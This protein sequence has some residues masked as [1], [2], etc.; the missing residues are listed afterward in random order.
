MKEN[1]KLVWRKIDEL[2]PYE[3][4]AKLHPQEQIDRLVGSFDE[5]GRIVPA[6]IDKDGNLI[7]GHGRILAARQRGDVDFPCIEIDGL[8]EVQ[9]RA[10]VHADNLLAQSDTDEAVLKAEMEALAAAGF[11]VTIAGFDADGIRIGEED[12]ETP[13]AHD[14]DYDAEPPEE[15][16]TKRGQ[17]WQLGEH[18]LL[19]GDATSAEDMADL[20]DERAQICFTSPPYNMMGGNSG[21][22]G[23]YKSTPNVAMRA[24]HCYVGNDD[25]LTDGDYAELLC[26]SLSAALDHCDDVLYNLSILSGS[27]YG[28]CEMLSRFRASLCDVI[29]WNKSQSMPSGLPSH[30]GML[31]HRCELIFAFSQSGH[32]M[33]T[34]PQFS[35]G[36]AINRIDTESGCGN[37]YAALHAATFPVALPAEVCK[38]FCD[39]GAVVLDPFG[40]SGSTL[41]ACEQLG[42]RC[43]MMEIDPHYCD[44]I[45]DRW[46]TFTGKK[47]VLLHGEG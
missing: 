23:S 30:H 3:H 36:T 21:R 24:G 10:F 15:P 5:F 47:A 44:V 35:N 12:A 43:R 28:I 27:K 31:S 6:G 40:G 42:R 25:D 9:R 20:M 17:L 33:F 1:I 29:V 38:L 39:P 34:H 37:K 45:I 4:N 46:E 13:E 22:G 7:Y 26:S 2:I 18:R 16:R 14:D 32:R 41:I 19:C 11:D 8:N